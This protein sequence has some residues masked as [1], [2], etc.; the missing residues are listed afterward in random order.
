[1]ALVD[2]QKSSRVLGSTASLIERTQ[3]FS[4]A[5][6]SK[7]GVLNQSV[8]RLMI[9]TIQFFTVVYDVGD[10]YDN[11]PATDQFF[12]VPNGV[13]R[14]RFF[15]STDFEGSVSFTVGDSVLFNPQ[16]NGVLLEGFGRPSFSLSNSGANQW[17]LKTPPFDVV[18]GDLIRLAVLPLVTP[19]SIR[20]FATISM[21]MGIEAVTGG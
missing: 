7:L 17:N 2:M 18:P 13:S 11:S 5:L 20:L 8:P 3:N 15:F 1:M 19:A 16:V 4:G 21:A 14:V 12:T 9:G 6:V 10:W